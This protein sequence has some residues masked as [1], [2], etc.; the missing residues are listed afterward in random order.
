MIPEIGQFA[1]ILALL[2]AAALA[3]QQQA[4]DSVSAL[5]ALAGPASN[6]KAIDSY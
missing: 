6:V 1:M 3:H 5:A 2:L 4:S